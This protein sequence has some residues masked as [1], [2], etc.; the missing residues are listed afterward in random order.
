MQVYG[1]LEKAQLEN[2]SADLSNT[3]AGLI[4]FNTTDSRAKFYDGSAIRAIVDENSTQTLTGKTFTAG[5]ITASAVSGDINLGT[6]TATNRIVVAKETRA[7][8]EALPRISGAV[9]YVTDEDIY[10]GDDGLNLVELGSGGAGGINYTLNPDA[11]TNA[12]DHTAYKDSASEVPDDAVGGAPTLAVARSTVNPLVGKA[13]FE[14]TKPA[15]NTQGEGINVGNK[16]FDEADKGKIQI[17]SFEYDGSNANYNDGDFRVFFKDETNGVIYRVNGEDI[18]GGRGTHYARV[19]VPID[20]DNG[21]LV[22]HCAASHSDAFTF[23]YDRVFFGPQNVVHGTII[24]DWKDYTP[25]GDWGGVNYVGKYRRVGDSLEVIATCTLLGG[26]AGNFSISLPPGLSIDTSKLSEANFKLPL[27]IARATDSGVGEANGFVSY[28]TQTAVQVETWRLTSSSESTGDL[29][30]SNTFPWTFT[31]N[32]TVNVNFRVPIAG[33]SSNT[34]TSEDF[35]GR[36]IYA[37][38]NSNSGEVI[39]SSTDVPF[40]TKEEDSTGSWN[41][42]QFIVPETGNYFI[43]GQ[44]TVT[45]SSGLNVN[46]TVD[47]ASSRLITDRQGTSTLHR[48]YT[49]E[50]FT[51]GQTI[52]IRP[53]S[54]TLTLSPGANHYIKIFKQASSQQILETEEV[55]LRYNSTSGQSM[56]NSATTTIVYNNKDH[57]THNAYNAS[58]GVFTAPYTGRYHISYFITFASLSANT[59]EIISILGP[60]GGGETARGFHRPVD[61]AGVYGVSFS[62]DIDLVKGDQIVMGVFHNNGAARPLATNASQNWLSIHKVK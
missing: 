35:G 50:R 41:G 7:N 44:I 47:G 10:V 39:N 24:E 60:S 61:R 52:S 4:W 14:I 3:L 28:Y 1:F 29:L 58:T 43:E 36:D 48:F 53:S 31:T 56:P 26:V 18:K 46:L 30:V 55:S 40:S 5:V 23:K 54:G 21:S 19:Q 25:T 13:S 57:D 51:K 62:G 8:L 20:C 38:Y 11:E 33:W 15:S 22:L 6:A 49:F 17:M 34:I 37:I 27:G 32:D 9:Y 42:S 12:N 45:S 2:V 59:G 16:D